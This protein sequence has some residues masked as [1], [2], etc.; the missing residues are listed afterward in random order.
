M[1]HPAPPTD[2]LDTPTH[3]WSQLAGDHRVQAIRLMAQLACNLASV[4]AAPSR[5]EAPH[6]LPPQQHETSL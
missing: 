4:Q 2:Y 5:Q 1:I 6:A 3:V